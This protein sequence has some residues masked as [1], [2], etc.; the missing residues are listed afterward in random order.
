MGQQVNSHHHVHSAGC[1]DVFQGEGFHV[2]GSDPPK[3]CQSQQ[4]ALRDR[5]A[6]VNFEYVPEFYREGFCA[7]NRPE[8]FGTAFAVQEA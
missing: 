2:S 5:I 8:F 3:P 6:P 4:V 7:K 1:D